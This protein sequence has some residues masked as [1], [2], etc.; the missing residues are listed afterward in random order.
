[1][2]EKIKQSK[3]IIVDRIYN[4]LTSNKEISADTF[5]GIAQIII[6]LDKKEKKDDELI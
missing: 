2:E 4:I 6:K 3:E 1:M 5:I